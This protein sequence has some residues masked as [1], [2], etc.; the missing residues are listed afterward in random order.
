[1]QKANLLR[2][3]LEKPI[4]QFLAGELSGS[5]LTDLGLAEYSRTHGYAIGARHWRRVFERVMDRD[6]GFGDFQRLD[7]YLDESAFS[8]PVQSRDMARAAGLHRALDDVLDNLE[9]RSNPTREDRAWLLHNVFEHFEALADG[10]QDSAAQKKAKKSLVHYIYAAV[11]AVAKNIAAF[12]KDFRTCFKRWSAGGKTEDS[13][14]D[15]RHDKSG[16]HRRPDFHRDENVIAGYAVLLGGNESLAMREAM[17][18][19]E[20]SEEFLSYYHHDPRRFKSYLA[21]RVRQ[22]VTPIVERL[23]SIHQGEQAAKLAGPYIKRTWGDDVVR[24]GDYFTADDMTQD[25]RTY[26]ATEVWVPGENGEPLMGE[27][28]RPVLLRAESIFFADFAS[29]YIIC[30]VQTTGRLNGLLIK[31]G[32]ARAHDQVGLPRRGFFFENG[33]WAS[34]FIHGEKGLSGGLHFRDFERNAYSHFGIEVHH[35][36]ARNPRAKPMES[37]FRRLQQHL[38]LLPGY[39]GSNERLAGFERTGEIFSAVRSGKADAASQLLSLPRYCELLSGIVTEFNEEPQNGA[40]LAGRSPLEAWRESVDQHPLRKLHPEERYLLATHCR[41]QT[42]TARGIILNKVPYSNSALFNWVGKKVLVWTFLETQDEIVVSGLD[43]KEF[44]SV[45]ANT[46]PA[47][48]ATKDQFEMVKSQ[49]CGF[50]RQARLEY[51]RIVHPVV[52][53]ITRD[54]LTDG[55]TKAL[56]AF[57]NEVAAAGKAEKTSRT[58]TLNK[59]GQEARAAGF[60]APKNPRNPAGVLTDLQNLDEL[61]ARIQARENNEIEEP[62]GK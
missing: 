39:T 57:T 13:I 5:A 14:L 6:R 51:D 4:R 36:E 62:N 53:N 40:R 11:P 18:R 2:E 24:P 37:I 30:F 42:V 22:N 52:S 31:A 27:N 12:D 9:N 45:K 20:L 15:R 28:G 59:I 3:A 58:R 1:V 17:K 33:V 46:L 32:I 49:I 47:T 48:G 54:T 25:N 43:K 56:G 10:C 7:L 61:R 60:V 19:G 35:H 21:K 50:N 16:H 26:L 23:A 44:F 55:P 38:P 29:D 34:R 41:Q 8:T